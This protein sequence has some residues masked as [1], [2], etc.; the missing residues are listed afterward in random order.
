MVEIQKRYDALFQ[1]MAQGVFFQE[2]S[3]E[4]SDVNPAAL[5]MFGLTRDQLLGRTSLHPDWK[6]IKED[7]S[8]LLPEQHPSMVALTTGKE[9]KDFIAGV[10]NPLL[11]KV[12]W[13]NINAI[14]MFRVGENTPYQAFVTLH[15]ISAQIKTKNVQQ[16]CLNLHCCLT[17]SQQA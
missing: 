9:V 4:L 7:G 2:S 5:E 15:D 17:V 14:P 16:S 1:N 8:D 10:Y 13:L 11:K 3:G 6:V 12:I